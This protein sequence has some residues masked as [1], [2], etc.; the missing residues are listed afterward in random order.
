MVCWLQSWQMAWIRA[1]MFSPEKQNQC[2]RVLR[3]VLGTVKAASD[4]GP[5]LSFLPDFYLET[6]VELSQALRSLFVPLA[7]LD[8]VPG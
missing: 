8:N 2:V 5:A 7:P 4:D 3:A 6:L 1:A